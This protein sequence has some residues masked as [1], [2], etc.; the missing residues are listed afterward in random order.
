MTSCA[1]VYCQTAPK[2]WFNNAREFCVSIGTSFLSCHIF[3]SLYW[4]SLPPIVLS[5]HYLPSYFLFITS[6]RTFYS[7]PPIVLSI[8]Y[9]PSYFL[10]IT[11]H[12]TFYSL[13]PIVLS[14]HY[15]P[16]YFLFTLRTTPTIISLENLYVLISD[17][18]S[19]F[20]FLQFLEND[21]LGTDCQI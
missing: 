11:S 2:D 4:Q 14:I 1:S 12:R 20:S 6:H 19:Q 16:S 15:L 3:L 7:L 5:I 10:F 18:K 21:C 8:H 9:L 17:M 13:P